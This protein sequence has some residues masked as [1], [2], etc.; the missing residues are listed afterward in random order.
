MLTMQ[1]IKAKAAL[2]RLANTDEGFL[3]VLTWLKLERELIVTKMTNHHSDTVVR[4]SQGA[5]Q[6]LDDLFQQIEEA[7]QG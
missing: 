6:V 5:V 7:R 1:S 4:Q 3:D 2:R